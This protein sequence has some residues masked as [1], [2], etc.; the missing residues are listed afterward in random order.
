[1]ND[2]LVSLFQKLPGVGPKQAKR[3]VYALMK[4]DKYYKDNMIREIQILHIYIHL[5]TNL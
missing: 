2:N 5:E 3:F 4:S 1:M